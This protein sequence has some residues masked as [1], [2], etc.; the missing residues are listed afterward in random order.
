MFLHIDDLEVVG[1]GKLLLAYAAKIRDC[2]GR[3]RARACY[4]EPKQVLGQKSSK[5]LLANSD[6]APRCLVQST[7]EARRKGCIS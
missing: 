2:G 6:N 3:A 1:T 5:S 7:R 4:E